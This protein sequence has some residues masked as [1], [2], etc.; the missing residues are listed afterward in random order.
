[1]HRVLISLSFVGDIGFGYSGKLGA[2]RA[3][4]EKWLLGSFSMRDI[5]PK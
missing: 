1:M 2:E 4:K 3:Y 5:Y